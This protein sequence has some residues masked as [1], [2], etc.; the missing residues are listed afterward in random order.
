MRSL[1]IGIVLVVLA[2]FLFVGGCN[3][4]NTF[5]NAEEEVENAWGNVQSVYQRRADLI[6]NLVNTVKGVAQFEQQTLTEV[7]NARA[8]ATQV[9]VDPANLTPEK[10]QEFQQAQ[11]Q[12]SQSLGRLLMITENYPELRASDSFRELQ[13]QLEGTEN[14]ISTERNR[15]NAVVTSYNKTVRR[16]PGRLYAGIF[17]FSSKAQFQ[18]EESAQTAPKVEF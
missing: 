4:Y 6:P 1:T 9:T 15:F 10:L 3:S 12:L 18:A 16:F 17:G 13:A 2:L 14:R 8:R 11:S 5:V 7:A